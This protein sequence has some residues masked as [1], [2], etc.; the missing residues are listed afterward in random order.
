ME[1]GLLLTSETVVWLVD[2]TRT[3]KFEPVPT[4]DGTF[5][6]CF[7]SLG[8]GAFNVFTFTPFWR[9]S[10]R[11]SGPARP[12]VDHATVALEPC[13]HV[14]PPFG[15]FTRIEAGILVASDRCRN[16][17]APAASYGKASN[18]SA[19]YLQSTSTA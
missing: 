14:S 12:C 8:T 15:F 17:S 4:V 2:T 5:T 7:P 6:F 16:C 3:R 11:T 18:C 1:N 13:T 10:I 9:S 19:A